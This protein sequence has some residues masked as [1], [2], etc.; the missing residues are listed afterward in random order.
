MQHSQGD[1]LRCMR[2]KKH[3]GIVVLTSAGSAKFILFRFLYSLS[4]PFPSPLDS[5]QQD[6]SASARAFAQKEDYR[7]YERVTP[8]SGSCQRIKYLE[9]TTSPGSYLLAAEVHVKTDRTLLGG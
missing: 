8:G 1:L 9:Y 3:P 7:N 4:F 5:G 6:P 2:S